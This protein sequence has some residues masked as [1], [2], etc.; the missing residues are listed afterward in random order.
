LTQGWG[1]RGAFNHNWDPYWSTSLFGGIAS[2]RYNDTAKALWCAAYSGTTPAGGALGPGFAIAG[3]PVT[4][5][6]AGVGPGYHC[7]PGFTMSQIGLITRWTPVKNLTFSGEVLY[8]YLKTNMAGEAQGTFT[9]SVPLLGAA[10][11][12]YGN[13]GT[14]SVNLRVQR[15]F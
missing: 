4:G 2:L 7:D 1:F 3:T 9:S 15:N 13:M 5:G 6:I 8:S 10:T 14:A 11:Y 12:Q